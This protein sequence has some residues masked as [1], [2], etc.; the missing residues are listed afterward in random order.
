MS[1][2]LDGDDGFEDFDPESSDKIEQHYIVDPNGIF[3]INIKTTK[4]KI[5]LK[6]R[7]QQNTKT[8]T[9]RLITRHCVEEEFAFKSVFASNGN[10]LAINPEYEKA[11]AIKQKKEEIKIAK[12]KRNDAAVWQY[13]DSNGKWQNYDSALST[14]I[15]IASLMQQ[16]HSFFDSQGNECKIDF[17]IM[18]ECKIQ[19]NISRPIRHLSQEAGF[20]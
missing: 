1:K 5:N 10:I 19:T 2:Y 14:Q 9:T 6:N 15:Q 11:Q 8:K 3:F 20:D 18:E 4:Y 13:L 17:T 7:S 16:S 12:Q